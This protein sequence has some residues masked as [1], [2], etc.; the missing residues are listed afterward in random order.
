MTS[1][2]ILVRTLYVCLPA[3]WTR[4]GRLAT[5]TAPEKIIDGFRQCIKTAEE[6][7]YISALKTTA[8]L[9]EQPEQVKHI[10]NAVGSPNLKATA[11]TG[12]F[13]I[14]GADPYEAVKLLIDD[15]G[16]VHLRIW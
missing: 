3:I 6:K 9:P 12:N 14:V 5:T 16:H 2:V 7:A 11:D 15:I 1:R 13:N 10:I 8:Y 4:R